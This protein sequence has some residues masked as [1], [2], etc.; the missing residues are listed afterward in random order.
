[1]KCRRGW[2]IGV[3]TQRLKLAVSDKKMFRPGLVLNVVF[4]ASFFFNDRRYLCY[5][6]KAQY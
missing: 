6:S 5:L 3:A 1:M 4:H 2:L